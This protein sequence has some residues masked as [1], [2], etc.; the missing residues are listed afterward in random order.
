M[1]K[2]NCFTKIFICLFACMSVFSVGSTVVSAVGNCTDSIKTVEYNGDGGAIGTGLRKKL[3]NTSSYVRND[4]SSKT[5]I[6]AGVGRSNTERGYLADRYYS[7]SNGAFNIGKMKYV[8]VGESKYLPNYVYE[9]GYRYAN[10]HFYPSKAGRVK[11][12]WSPDSV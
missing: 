5:A 11:I 10:V 4:S 8:R 2:S 12:Y 1:K 3:D 6:S 9:D 7:S